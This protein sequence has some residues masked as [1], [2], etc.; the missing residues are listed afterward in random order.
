MLI[1]IIIMITQ[2]SKIL[3]DKYDIEYKVH[4]GYLDTFRVITLILKS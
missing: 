2:D 1:S 4:N 3:C